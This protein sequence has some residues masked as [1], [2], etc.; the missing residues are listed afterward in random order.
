MLNEWMEET[1]EEVLVVNDSCEAYT[2]LEGLK[3]KVLA[4]GSSVKDINSVSA[5]FDKTLQMAKIDHFS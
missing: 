3:G 1:G 2:M 4:I 5:G